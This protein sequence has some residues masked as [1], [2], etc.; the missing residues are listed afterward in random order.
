MNEI[1][2]ITGKICRSHNYIQEAQTACIVIIVSEQTV[3]AESKLTHELIVHDT[4]KWG[5]FDHFLKVFLK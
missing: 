2:V 3:C 4:L 5:E 1:P